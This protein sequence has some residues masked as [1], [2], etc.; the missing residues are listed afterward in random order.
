M[1]A[2]LGGLEG[3]S[4]PATRHIKGG[5]EAGRAS[6]IRGLHEVV[7]GT[8]GHFLVVRVRVGNMAEQIHAAKPNPLA[9]LR[10]MVGKRTC[11]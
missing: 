9:Y 4:V 7:K 11:E 10:D 2:Q 5:L 1:P 6:F 8:P 3:C